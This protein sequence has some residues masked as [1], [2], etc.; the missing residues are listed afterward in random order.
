MSYE[1]VLGFAQNMRA[2]L[3]AAE[4]ERKDLRRRLAR[5]LSETRRLREE[6]ISGLGKFIGYWEPGWFEQERTEIR[7]R[8]R[9]CVERK[10]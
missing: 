8:R 4:D 10:E 5:A 7:A 1:D 3:D 2:V 9:K 6:N